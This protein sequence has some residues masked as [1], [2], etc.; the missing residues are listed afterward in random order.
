MTKIIKREIRNYLKRPWFWL[1]VLLVI[2]GTFQ[3]LEPYLK[4]HYIAPEE[5]LETDLPKRSYKGDISEG[6]VPATK[7]QRRK[8]WDQEMK[9]IFLK[10][11]QMN[12]E[13]AQAVIDEMEDMDIENACRYLEE[14][15]QFYGAI[16]TYEDTAWHLGTR[17]EINEGKNGG[18]T[19]FLVFFQ[20][21]CRLCGAVYGILCR[22]YAGGSFLPGYQKKYL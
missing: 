16:Y 5:K 6:Y 20:E 22:G 15:Y 21:V 8:M 9:E 4:I 18:Q 1:G 7:E 12:E 11:Y 10:E 3:N 17:E 19:L 14:N 13:E 2:F